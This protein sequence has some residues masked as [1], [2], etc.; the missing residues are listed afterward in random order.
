[1][2]VCAVA[3]RWSNDPL[4]TSPSGPEGVGT[5]TAG[6]ERLACG[7]GWFEQVGL[8]YS[9]SATRSTGVA[10]RSDSELMHY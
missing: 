3:S 1:M 6:A 2:L 4:V 9:L 7:W 10:V 8:G 5:Q